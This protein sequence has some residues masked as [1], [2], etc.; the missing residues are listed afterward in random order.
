MR[1]ALA[2]LLASHISRGHLWDLA[3]N[4]STAAAMSKVGEIKI[5]TMVDEML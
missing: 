1:F 3:E 4:R 2:L 5:N